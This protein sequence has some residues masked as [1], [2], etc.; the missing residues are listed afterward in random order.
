MNDTVPQQFF[1]YW[2]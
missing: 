1:E 2:R